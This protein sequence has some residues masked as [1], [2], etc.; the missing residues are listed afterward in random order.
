M[1]QL[2][3]LVAKTANS[4]TASKSGGGCCSYYMTDGCEVPEASILVLRLP[5]EILKNPASV[6]NGD[7]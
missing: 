2:Q 7:K 6:D 5:E 3:S 1:S 4:M